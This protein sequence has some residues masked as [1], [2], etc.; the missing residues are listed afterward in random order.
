MSLPPTGRSGVVQAE[1]SR[2]TPTTWLTV[3]PMVDHEESGSAPWVP[4]THPSCRIMEGYTRCT[5]RTAAS[6]WFALTRRTARPFGN[7]LT[8]RLI[9]SNGYVL[10]FGTPLHSHCLRPFCCLCGDDREVRLSQQ[11]N[12]K[13]DLEP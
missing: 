10:R 8:L 1:T 2:L 12:W 3:G 4:A 11:N 7:I 6:L 9:S 13:R 5:A